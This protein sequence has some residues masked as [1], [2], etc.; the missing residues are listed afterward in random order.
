MKDDSFLMYSPPA[1]KTVSLIFTHEELKKYY[2]TIRN[3]A[4]VDVNFKLKIANA[5]LDF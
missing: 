2:K 4:R 3:D 1:P 5:I